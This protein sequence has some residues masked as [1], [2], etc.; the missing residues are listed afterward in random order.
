MGSLASVAGA[1]SPLSGEIAA[2]AASLEGGEAGRVPPLPP[3]RDRGVPDRRCR[4]A[5]PADGLSGGRMKACFEIK[6]PRV[7]SHEALVK[8]LRGAARC[9][10]ETSSELPTVMQGGE[11]KEIEILRKMG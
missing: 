11:K 5:L 3:R 2:P 8:K 10:P 7:P 6:L 9:K 1:I 4:R